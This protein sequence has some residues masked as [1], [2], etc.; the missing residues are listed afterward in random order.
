MATPS[1]ILALENPMDRGAWHATVHGV[2]ESDM[3]KWM[4][5][6]IPSQKLDFTASS[7]SFFVQSKTTN[8]TAPSSENQ[9]DC[10][11]VSFF[12]T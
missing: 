7:C 5:T 1:S 6:H 3:T 11:H 12:M 8:L 4:S 2:T 10:V 9:T